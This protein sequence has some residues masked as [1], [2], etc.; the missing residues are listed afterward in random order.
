M[1]LLRTDVLLSSATV[2]EAITTSALLKL[3][4]SMPTAEKVAR[5]D[6]ILKELVRMRQCGRAGWECSALCWR[7]QPVLRAAGAAVTLK[8]KWQRKCSIKWVHSIAAGPGGLPAHADRR[9]NAA[10]EGH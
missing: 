9:R 6:G 10:R 7:F 2:R 1:P 3:P 4:R 5:V 8:V